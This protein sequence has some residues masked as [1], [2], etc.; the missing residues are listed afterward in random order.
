MKQP[1]VPVNA[2]I[3]AELYAEMQAWRKAQPAPP[4]LTATVETAI[5]V[6]IEVFPAGRG[7]K[8]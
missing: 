4:T 3:P 8:S 5:R 6:L 2:R 7:K 1:K